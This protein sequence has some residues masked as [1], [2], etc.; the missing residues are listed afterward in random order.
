M[1]EGLSIRVGSHDWLIREPIG[2]GGFG[3][4]FLAE[5]G[6]KQAVIKVV[7]KDPGASREL[8]F[9][10]D[11]R[12]LTHIVPVIG[13]SEAADS[14][15]LLMPKAEMSLR[16]YM[17]R[18][19]RQ[20]PQWSNES[21]R[22]LADI[23]TALSQISQRG[24]VHRDLKPEN[25]LLLDGRWRLADF[26]ISRYREVTTAADTRKHSM[27]GP[28]A[29]PEQWR[30]ERA[31]AATDIYAFGVIAFELLSG[32]WPF[33]GPSY[34]EFRDQHLHDAPPALPHLPASIA[35]LIEECLTKAPGARPSPGNLVARIQRMADSNPNAVG[36]AALERAHYVESS[37]RA[38]V[39]RR[40]SQVESELTRRRELCVAASQQ[41]SK[42]TK[43]LQNTIM[44]LAP[45]ATLHKGPALRLGRRPSEA[46]NVD[47]AVMSLDEQWINPELSIVLGD[48][49]LYYGGLYP[50]MLQPK[51][52]FDVVAETRIAV[53]QRRDRTRNSL[54]GRSHSLWFS[55]ARERGVYRWFEIS[56]AR[57]LLGAG[58]VG[59]SDPVPVPGF[60][61]VFD[62]FAVRAFDDR[63][64]VALKS[65]WSSVKIAWPIGAVSTENMGPF[66]D[67]W[68]QWLAAAS[69]A[70]LVPAPEHGPHGTWRSK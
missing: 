55:D 22:V 34:P 56:F 64:R 31:T 11:L 8:L 41:L 53:A 35:S 13:T 28:Y 68:S 36:L 44:M 61:G 21:L 60:E 29:A 32:S 6:S 15:V 47:A 67:R 7:P 54:V 58:D 66:V 50:L 3:N 25:I 30:S 18:S 9:A 17:R 26:G 65:R 49:L 23:A 14:W 37:K 27:T 20:R 2:S 16:D 33:R 4:V 62:P 57:T 1:R 51:L 10:D 70:E 5:R 45:S 19:R 40:N 63:A 59:L 48:G 39:A 42:I 38:A 43:E 52:P 46:L 12:H 24:V 69:N